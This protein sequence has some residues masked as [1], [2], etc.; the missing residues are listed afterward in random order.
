MTMADLV[1]VMGEGRIRQAGSPLDIYR[2]PSD[3]FVA[4][5][6]GS[7]NLIPARADGGGASLLGGRIEGLTLPA[8]ASEAT[9]SVRPEDIRLVA[10]SA[11]PIRGRVTFVRDLGASVETFLDCDGRELVAVSA[12]R[13]RPAVHEGAE[14]GVLIAAQ[15]C[16]VLA[17]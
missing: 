6:I 9:V 8:G 1:V 17:E 11:A 13:D 15:D 12:P 14:I 7:T 16:V 10:P 5:F 3:A 2:R 4:A